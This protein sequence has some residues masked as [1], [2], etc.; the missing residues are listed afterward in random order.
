MS[1]IVNNK[2]KIS[3]CAQKCAFSYK[4]NMVNKVNFGSAPLQLNLAGLW[5]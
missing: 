4:T 3:Y 1:D 5:T 2:E